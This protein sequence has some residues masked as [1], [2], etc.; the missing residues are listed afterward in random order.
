MDG[1]VIEKCAALAAQ[2]HGD[3]RRAL[4]L[5]RV[6]GELA[7]RKGDKKTTTVHVDHAEDRIDI[8]RVVQIV[9]TQPRQSQAV[10]YSI[11]QLGKT[12]IQTADIVNRYQEIC[13]KHGL[14]ELTQR[15]I[16]DL[17]SEL[18]LFGIINSKVI[19]RGRHGRTRIINLSLDGGLFDKVLG[20]LSEVF[21]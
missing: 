5:L 17:I 6:A 16:S 8:D 3:A 7:E 2:E 19:S 1:G 11:M 15:R 12:N 10:L 14:K 20:V 13:K 4:D 9:K 21:Y 18:D